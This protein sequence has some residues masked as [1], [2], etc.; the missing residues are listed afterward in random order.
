ME[1]RENDVSATKRSADK[2]RRGPRKSLSWFGFLLGLCDRDRFHR[3]A[4]AQ[5]NTAGSQGA[6]NK[7]R[8]SKPTSTHAGEWI[9]IS[10]AYR[11][12]TYVRTHACT[13]THKMLL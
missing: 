13:V 1:G 11:C 10:V 3:S 8:N 7:K 4:H 12:A 9:F 6:K 5:E 2:R